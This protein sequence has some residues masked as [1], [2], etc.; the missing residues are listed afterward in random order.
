MRAHKGMATPRRYTPP[1][2]PPHEKRCLTDRSP[3]RTGQTLK[4]PHP[5]ASCVRR[6]LVDPSVPSGPA[7]RLLGPPS[8]RPTHGPD[9]AHRCTAAH[10]ARSG[11]TRTQTA[12]HGAGPP[13]SATRRAA[14]GRP[15]AW[16]CVRRWRQHLG[17]PGGQPRPFSR[18]PAPQAGARCWRRPPQCTRHA[19][20]GTGRAVAQPVG[21]KKEGRQLIFSSSSVPAVPA[22]SPL[23]PRSIFSKPSGPIARIHAGFRPMGPHLSP[24][25]RPTCAL[26]RHFFDHFH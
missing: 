14:P 26:R 20:Q 15:C 21:R 6:N 3:T 5:P 22:L 18:G 16:W 12:Q 17:P 8:H 9:A 11:Y 7:C 2:K 24:L 13:S 25:P 4:P 23:C 10:R 1:P 19:V